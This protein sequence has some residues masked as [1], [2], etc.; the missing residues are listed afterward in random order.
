M[1]LI[2]VFGQLVDNYYVLI[3]LYIRE[4]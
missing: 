2:K 1:N 4:V 3:G